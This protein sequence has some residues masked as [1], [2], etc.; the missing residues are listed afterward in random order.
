M[1]IR[2]YPLTSQKACSMKNCPRILRFLPILL[3]VL[4]VG[5]FHKDVETD[6]ADDIAGNLIYSGP[7]GNFVLSKEEIF[8]A[9]SK[10][11]EG[12]VTHISGYT[13]YRLS[14]YDI[15]TGNQ[16]GRVAIGE[17]IEEANA[18]IGITP[19]K[20]WM[21]SI[22]PELGLHYRDPKTLEPKATWKELS[23][24]PGLGSYKP[25]R[26]DWPLIYQYFALD[27]ARQKLMITDEAGFRYLLDPETLAL[28]KID[29]TMPEVDWDPTILNSS[30]EFAE[31]DR[32]SLEGDP[33][34][35]I[36]YRGKKTSQD[37]SFLFGEWLLDMDP[38]KAAKRDKAK[39]AS[40]EHNWKSLQDS[41]SIYS[42]AHPEATQE[43]DYM[44]WT[45]DQR[46][47]H[48][49]ADDLRR[50]IEDAKRKIDNSNQRHD[51]TLDYPLLTTDGKSAYIRHAGVVADTAHAIISRVNLHPDSTWSI[52]WSAT[53]ANI[54]HNSSKADQAGAFEKVYSSG[55]PEFNYQWAGQ[56]GNYLLY[57]AQLQMICL[58]TQTGK[59][60]WEKEL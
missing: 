4:S 2:N 25:A 57:V 58:D 19:G 39:A 44:K 22:D 48:D 12:G 43:P 34:K 24:K 38:L 50:G 41:L 21:F 49:H 10:S 9:N 7:E 59:I 11:S 45:F 8:Q 17:M 51:P 16:V 5:C 23:Q 6:R 36:S 46:R 56:F 27:Y 30:G 35:E 33:R 37:V 28:E 29:A 55:N 14:S 60:L 1:E 40:L 26:P 42:A 53:L 31:D 3:S 32:V 54:Y 18:L 47:I 52:A 13:E 15:A 20:V